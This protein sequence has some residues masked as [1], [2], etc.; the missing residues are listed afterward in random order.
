M[1]RERQREHTWG[2]V[3]RQRV[4][5]KIPSRP[6]TVSAEPDG[7]LEPL[8]CEIMTRAKIKSQVLTE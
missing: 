2:G 4:R 6:C 1:E 3:E 5:E 7:G 8:N